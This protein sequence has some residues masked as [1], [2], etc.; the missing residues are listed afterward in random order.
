L[1]Q[2][3]LKMPIDYS[4]FDSI[5]DSDEEKAAP[6]HPAFA[7]PAR[8]APAPGGPARKKIGRD[9]RELLDGGGLEEKLTLMPGGG[10]SSGSTGYANHAQANPQDMSALASELEKLASSGQ[11]QEPKKAGEPQRMCMRADGRKKI[12]T[13]F[14]DGAEMVEEYD[15]KTDVLLIRKTRKPSTLGKEGEWV[16]EVGQAPEAAFDPHADLMRASAANPIF[17]RKDTPEHFQWRIR[18][19]TYPSDVYSVSADHEKQEIVV[20][21]SNKKYYKRIQVPDL[22]RLELKLKDELLSWKHQHNTLI[23]SYSKPSEV[24]EGEQKALREAE[25]TAVKL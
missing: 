9:G 12:H 16:F 21:T 17:L 1:L 4:K 24:L 14:P 22:A 8:Q 2:L 5:D 23:I 11:P 13:T 7:P 19:L 3:V 15:E 10:G 20:R 18:N 6:S 25:K